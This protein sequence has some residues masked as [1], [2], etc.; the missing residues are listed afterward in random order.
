MQRFYSTTF[1]LWRLLMKTATIS[2]AKPV[3]VHINT[4]D[5]T[6]SQWAQ[7]VTESG[8]ILH[9]GQPKYIRRVAK[10]RFNLELRW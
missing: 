10:T 1:T 5:K 9:T 3:N 2:L 6:K 4:T 8:I 7:I